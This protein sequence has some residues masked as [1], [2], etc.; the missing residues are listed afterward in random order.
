MRVPNDT[1]IEQVLIVF[2]RVCIGW[3]FLHAGLDQV[4][5]PHFSATGFLSHVKTFHNEFAP[6]TAPGIVPVVSFIVEWG[7]V[8]LGLSLILGAF[9]R[10]SAIFG[11]FLMLTFYLAHMNWPYNDSRFYFIVGPHLIFAGILLYLLVK[12][13]GHILGV[14]GWLARYPGLANHPLLKPCL[15]KP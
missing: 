11:I 2:F 3:I 8:L 7:Q 5:Q 9:V 1:V 6:L 10:V 12:R 13:A 15:G 4:L 14:D